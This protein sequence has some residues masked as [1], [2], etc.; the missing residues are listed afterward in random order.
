MR[1]RSRVAMSAALAVT[2][3]VVSFFIA[4]EGSSASTYPEAELCVSDNK[5]YTGYSNCWS[6]K[7]GD[8]VYVNSLG[9]IADNDSISSYQ[10]FSDISGTNG[11]CYAYLYRNT[12]HSGPYNVI[13]NKTSG[14]RGHKS[15]SGVTNLSGTNYQH[16][17]TYANDSISSLIIGCSL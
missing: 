11:L 10:L 9:S 7:Y 13:L 2:S 5:N 17:G 6:T 16:G 12:T 3:S 8:R 4:C 15:G 1:V 14:F